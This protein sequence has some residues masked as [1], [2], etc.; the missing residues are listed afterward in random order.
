MVE[1]MASGDSNSSALIANRPL[2]APSLVS[3][4]QSLCRISTCAEDHLA[5]CGLG[6]KPNADRSG[7]QWALALCVRMPV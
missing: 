7:W 4:C 5:R 2:Q 3:A 1:S 6:E